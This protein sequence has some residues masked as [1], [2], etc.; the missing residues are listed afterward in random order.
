MTARVWKFTVEM[1]DDRWR[2]FV[3]LPYGAVP[4]SVGLQGATM[5]LWALVTD[6]EVPS[7]SAAEGPHRLIVANTG[8]EIPHFPDGAR[9]LGTITSA[10][11]I[12]WHVWD[13]DA[14]TTA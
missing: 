9:F 14:E 2:S 3:T 1:P 11:G 4:I 13:G 6:E 10:N 5:V 8:G 7:D 12:V